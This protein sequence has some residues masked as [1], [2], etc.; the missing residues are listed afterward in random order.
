MPD[1]TAAPE[2]GAPPAEPATPPATPATPAAP[3][4]GASAGPA[5]LPSDHPLVKAYE[6]TRTEL[7]SLK[8]AEKTD[9]QRAQDDLAAETTRAD[10]LQT[11]LHQLRAALNHGL[12][13]E[14][15]DLLGT[16]TAEEIEARAKR[17]AERGADRKKQG[18]QAPREGR[19]PPASGED[20]D[21]EAVRAIFGGGD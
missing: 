3:E 18:N 19:Q 20:E 17:L 8:D 11:E 21:R 4:P 1:A 12:D 9:L 2:P 10:G 6:A 14:D 15:V 16:G 7:K 13:L 5:R